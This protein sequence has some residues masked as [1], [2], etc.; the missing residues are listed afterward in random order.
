[1]D[2]RLVGILL[3]SFCLYSVVLS[4]SCR[5]CSEV[6]CNDKTEKDCPVG[7]VSNACGCCKVCAKNKGEKCGGPWSTQGVCGRGLEC[8]KPTPPPNVNEY[9][10][11][12]NSRGVCA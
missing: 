3:L 12:F 4:L 6:Q 8:V 11:K 7:V 2:V 10:H 9:L 1:M 5:P